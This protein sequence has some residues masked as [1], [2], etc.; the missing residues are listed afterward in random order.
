[1][2]DTRIQPQ[3]ASG[4]T[5]PQTDWTH[6]DAATALALT[7]E[8]VPSAWMADQV[9]LPNTTAFTTP[10][11]WDAREVAQLKTPSPELPMAT[12]PAMLSATILSGD[13]WA[14]ES[15]IAAQI[16]SPEVV[17]PVFFGTM[18]LFFAGLVFRKS[19]AVAVAGLSSVATLRKRVEA[20]DNGSGTALLALKNKTKDFSG[21]D[22]CGFYHWGHIDLS[23]YNFCGAKLVAATFAKGGGKHALKSVHFRNASFI[24]ADLSGA[25]LPGV[26]FTGA[27]LSQARFVGAKMPYALLQNANL[28]GANLEHAELTT[29]DLR[30]ADLRGAN[31]RH[32]NLSY[33]SWGNGRTL[34]QGTKLEGADFRGATLPQNLSGVS[35]AGAIITAQQKSQIEWGAGSTEGAVIH[36]L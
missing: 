36:E 12:S 8:P 28:S 24:S 14:G 25:I 21:I 26:V 7:T 27:N 17:M 16:T 33:N 2:F 35:F 3:L 32:A 9:T 29:S 13:A 22:L 23:G 11:I 1:M 5:A 15:V 31:L 10:Q 34:L 30:G 4:L 20:H 18:V 6:G 19:I